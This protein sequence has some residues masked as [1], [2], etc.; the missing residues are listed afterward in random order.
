MEA[1][2]GAIY[3]DSDLNM[4]KCKDVADA[5][6]LLPREQKWERRLE[7]EGFIMLDNDHIRPHGS[8]KRSRLTSEKEGEC[9]KRIRQDRL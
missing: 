4:A 5:L 7:V 9:S 6:E 1:I 8:K 3:L 2:L